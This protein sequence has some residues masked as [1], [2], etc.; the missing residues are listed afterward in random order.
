MKIKRLTL[1]LSASFG[2]A[3]N[4]TAA[5]SLLG[6][7]SVSLEDLSEFAAPGDNWALGSAISN[8]P[9]SDTSIALA[10]GDGILAN[11]A[12]KQ[13]G[14]NL[15]TAWEHGDIELQLEF[16]M[17]QGSN[18][19]IYLQSRYEIQLFDSWGVENPAFSDCGGIYQRWDS[20]RE[21]KGFEG[22][23]PIVNASRAPGLWQTLHIVFRAPRFDDS[24]AKTENAR[25]ERVSLNGFLLHENVEVTGPTRAA[26]FEDE[27]VLAPLMIQGDHGPV[28]FRN[29]RLKHYASTP[30]AV[31][32]L[33]CEVREG[34]EHFTIGHYDDVT[35]TSSPKVTA[36]DLSQITP[37]NK[38]AA[39]F[40][41]NFQ[42]PTDGLY[43]FHASAQGPTRLL[44]GETEAIKPLSPG[45]RSIPIE[46]S[47][48]AHAF[49]LDYTHGRWRK[50]A[51]ELFVEGPGVRMTSLSKPNK[52]P[53]AKPNP[54]KRELVIEPQDGR[55]RIQRGF[56][57]HE[58]VKRLYA[59]GVGSPHKIHYAYD[60]DTA[61]ILHAWNGRFIDT[62]E[63]WDGRGNRQVAKPAGPLL[64]LPA[65]PTI[66]LIESSDY[67]FPAV[68]D[69]MWK[70]EGY[71]LDSKG[72][73]TF[74]ASI[75]GIKIEDRIESISTKRELKRTLTINGSHT[76]WW[77]GVLLAESSQI[78]ELGDGSYLVGDREYYLD[79]AANNKV[80]PF[81]RSING[82]EQ[83]MFWAPKGANGSTTTYTLVW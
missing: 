37:T 25:F 54:Q 32:D 50:A 73:P 22:V 5:D 72:Q 10:N 6:F 38:L 56:I 77:T 11:L 81:I 3:F 55:V 48:G 19:G 33:A 30:I 27:T 64:T 69:R 36:I 15:F 59:M 34:E 75:A 26:A 14:K 35:P 24:G 41:G 47:A 67:D 68:P 28:A 2:L 66:S 79:L 53:K 8:N 62:F 12:P 51:L 76:S 74:H 71:T 80:E 18:S 63:M 82:K 7:S 44:I 31:T 13:S 70:S 21:E 45:G 16:L 61:A 78:A 52:K 49:R 57:P 9:R 43:A 83:L 39:T 4:A 42:I 23:D 65:K 20:S 58:P 17:P 29:I 40:T 46:L 60:E 1:S